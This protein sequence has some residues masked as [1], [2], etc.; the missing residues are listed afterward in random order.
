MKSTLLKILFFSF[1]FI[2]SLSLENLSRNHLHYNIDLCFITISLTS[3][4][5]QSSFHWIVYI[6]CGITYDILIFNEPIGIHAVIYLLISQLLYHLK[7]NINHNNFPELWLVFAMLY[8][9]SSATQLLLYKNFILSSLALKTLLTIFA[10][11]IIH[12][13]FVKSF[14]RHW[15]HNV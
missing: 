1:F 8:I 10:Y 13:I 5:R 7:Y 6:M 2:L 3:L 11:P 12:Y 14:S 9:S 15:A 4:T